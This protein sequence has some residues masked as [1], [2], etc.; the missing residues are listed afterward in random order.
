MVNNFIEFAHFCQYIFFI[1]PDKLWSTYFTSSKVVKSLI[2]IYGKDSFDVEIRKTFSD[3]L[4][5]R[6]WEA[7]FLHRVKAAK[8][9]M[10]LNKHNGGKGFCNKSGYMHN[11][12]TIA[13]MKK[14]KPAGFG[15]IV[16]KNQKGKPKSEEHKRK[17]KLAAQKR[18]KNPLARAEQSRIKKGVIP[19]NKGLIGA[20]VAW[21]KGLKKIDN[22]VR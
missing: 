15:E 4:V 14:P 19:W 1:H 16:S 10:W 13:K 11:P 17:I 12:E 9:E 8:S 18:W 6:N 2:E 3:P 7:K 20:Q 22:A 21:N 5:C